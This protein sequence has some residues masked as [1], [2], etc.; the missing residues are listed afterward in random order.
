VPNRPLAQATRHPLIAQPTVG[1]E[2][3]CLTIQSGAPPDSP[4]IFSRD[5]P[6]FPESDEFV[7]EDL[8][9]GADDSPDSPVRHRIVR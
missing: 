4:V 5:A 6:P 9:A 3:L 1:H 7:A 2:G 8:G